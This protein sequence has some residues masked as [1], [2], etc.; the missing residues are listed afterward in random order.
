MNPH[1]RQSNLDLARNQPAPPA[2]MAGGEVPATAI[3]AAGLYLAINLAVWFGA[4]RYYS[5]LW[6][7][8]KQRRRLRS[9]R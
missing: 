2:V 4:I 1:M 3:L 7:E 8:R 6:R 9:V 5:G